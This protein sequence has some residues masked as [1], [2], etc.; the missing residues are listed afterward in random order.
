MKES[1]SKM[2]DKH[3]STIEYTRRSTVLS[4]RIL[5]LLEIDAGE[6]QDTL[7][8][9]I[10]PKLYFKFCTFGRQLIRTFRSASKHSELN[11]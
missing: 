10:P 9:Y 3:S 5:L 1:L 2:A 8:V 6:T 4:I 7:Y 11:Y